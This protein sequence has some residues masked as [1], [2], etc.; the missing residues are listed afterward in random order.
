MIS[1]NPNSRRGGTLRALAWVLGA[2]GAALLVTALLA[3]KGSSIQ[4]AMKKELDQTN[5]RLRG[6]FPDLPKLPLPDLPGPAKEDPKD[7]EKVKE[8]AEDPT[9]PVKPDAGGPPPKE[10][11]EPAFTVKK[12]PPVAKARHTVAKG[13]TLY[14]LAETYYEDGSLW[15]LIAKANSI[16]D[17]A[18]L[19]QGTVIVIPGK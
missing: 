1:A 15:S 2:L 7:P 3:F 5:E 17:P 13:D 16:K 11:Q 10:P 8:P 18:E 4:A 6:K 9:E 14:S 12:P 19:K